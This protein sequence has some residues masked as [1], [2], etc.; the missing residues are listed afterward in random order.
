ME[1]LLKKSFELW[2]KKKWLKAIDKEIDRYNHLRQKTKRQHH[3]LST[4][5]NRYN[6]I[7]GEDLTLGGKKK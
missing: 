7:Y 4:M 3:I 6:E 2:Y 5:I 1:E